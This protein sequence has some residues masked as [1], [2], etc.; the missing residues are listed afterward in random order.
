MK[1]TQSSFS[2][3]QTNTA[4]Q[5][6]DNEWLNQIDAISVNQKPPT[7]IQSF[8][9]TKSENDQIFKDMIRITQYLVNNA[10]LD[11]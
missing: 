2:Q 6:D 8:M 9:S 10:G 11:E 1:R 5:V 3:K 4:Q 7:P